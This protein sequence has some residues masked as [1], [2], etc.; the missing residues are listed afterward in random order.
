MG[1]SRLA[2]VIELHHFKR[3]YWCAPG[4]DGHIVYRYVGKY[5]DDGHL[6][7]LLED[8]HG[9]LAMLPH[10]G[11]AT[12]RQRR[13]LRVLASSSYFRV[14]SGDTSRKVP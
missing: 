13:F 1:V 11:V 6:V 4:E 14:V 9:V 2:T 8:L 10:E 12:P 7:A 5:F 3:V